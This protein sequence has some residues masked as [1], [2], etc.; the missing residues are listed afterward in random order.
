MVYYTYFGAQKLQVVQADIATIDSDAVV[1]PTNSDF[2]TGG[3]VGNGEFSA[4]DFVCVCMT[5][6]Q[7][8]SWSTLEKRGGKEFLEAVVEVRKKNGPLDT[9]G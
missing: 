2:Y 5:N 4:A 8:Q 3:E 1:H 6:Q 9:A 7:Q